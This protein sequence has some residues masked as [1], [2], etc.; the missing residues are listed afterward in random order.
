M[1]KILY[2][3]T[4]LKKFVLSDGEEPHIEHSDDEIIITRK[5]MTTT[6]KSKNKKKKR[7]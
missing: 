4:V 5:G 3:F 6:I 7:T 1:V 2:V